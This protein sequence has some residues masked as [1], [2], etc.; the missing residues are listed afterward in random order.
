[1]G[2]YMV[3]YRGGVVWND[4]LDLDA[5]TIYEDRVTVN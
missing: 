1:M 2:I 5:D 3:Y 4:D